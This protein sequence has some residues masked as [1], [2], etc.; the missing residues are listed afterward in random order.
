METFAI[1]VLLPHPV[2]TL[3]VSGCSSLPPVHPASIAGVVQD[4]STL[5]WHDL[6]PE[7]IG[8]DLGITEDFKWEA[9]LLNEEIGLD[10]LS[11]GLTPSQW[12]DEG[13]C[14]EAADFGGSSDLDY[15]CI[16]ASM[17]ADFLMMHSGS[18]LPSAESFQALDRVAAQEQA[19]VHAQ[20]AGLR[21]EALS[22]AFNLEGTFVA[23]PLYLRGSNLTC[24]ARKD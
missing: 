17:Q 5:C 3:I 12:E 8:A 14:L 9:D 23:N 21:A 22:W 2:L 7:Q 20:R 10:A 19:I 24:H 11:S 16:G 13:Y 6:G 15:A 4:S 18:M 1:T